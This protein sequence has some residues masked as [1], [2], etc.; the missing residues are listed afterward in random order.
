[1]G[2]RHLIYTKSSRYQYI[3]AQTFV[4]E[5]FDEAS[6]SYLGYFYFDVNFISM[7]IQ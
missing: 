7:S 6:K 1:M 5:M 2:V 4:F 3:R